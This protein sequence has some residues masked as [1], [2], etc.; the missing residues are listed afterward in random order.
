MSSES[1]LGALKSLKL[2]GMAQAADEL[3]RPGA[4]AFSTIKPML[5]TLVE[6]ERAEREVRSINYQIISCRPT[7]W[8]PSST[9]LSTAPSSSPWKATAIVSKRPRN[10]LSKKPRNAPLS[11]AKRNQPD[12]NRINTFLSSSPSTRA[13]R[14]PLT[15]VS[16]SPPRT[17]P[18]RARWRNSH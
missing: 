6:A 5:N 11:D 4:P 15:P 16:V 14:S 8:S 2:H 18:K 7:V 9:G 1:L 13:F 17:R 12:D 3:A 10:A